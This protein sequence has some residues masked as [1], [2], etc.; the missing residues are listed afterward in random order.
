M[1]GL[2]V[3]TQYD[4]VTDGQTET[5]C[6]AVYCSVCCVDLQIISVNVSIDVNH[7]GILGTLIGSRMQLW[8]DVISISI[9]IYLARQTSSQ[10]TVGSTRLG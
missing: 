1:I 3:S 6:R 4:R 2:I 10:D 8:N 5:L 9:K 7:A